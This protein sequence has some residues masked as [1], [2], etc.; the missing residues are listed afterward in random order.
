MAVSD[1]R[2]QDGANPA[3]TLFRGTFDRGS[4]AD[5]G[6]NRAQM[7]CSK[8]NA[9]QETITNGPDPRSVEM[10]PHVVLQC[11]FLEYRDYKLVYRRYASLFFIVG[12]DDEEVRPARRLVAFECL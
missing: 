10:D 8:G 12:V 6:R 1:P 3:C 11:A 9:G 4:D 7:S 2:E 5:G